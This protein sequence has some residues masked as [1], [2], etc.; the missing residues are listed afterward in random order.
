MTDRRRYSGGGEFLSFSF[1]SISRIFIFE[2]EC[3]CRNWTIFFLDENKSISEPILIEKNLFDFVSIKTGAAVKMEHIQAALDPRKQELLEARFLGARVSQSIFKFHIFDF[4]VNF[5]PMIFG[6][7][8]NS[9]AIWTIL[10]ILSSVPRTK[11]THNVH[12]NGLTEESTYVF[13][14]R[15]AY[16][17]TRIQFSMLHFDSFGLIRRSKWRQKFTLLFTDDR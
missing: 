1:R 3:S 8:R 13:V 14:S 4:C 5:V 10:S 12:T 2:S 7:R 16:A 9:L 17:F 6:S 11:R 15:G